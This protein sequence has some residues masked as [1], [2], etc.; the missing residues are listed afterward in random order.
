MCGSNEKVGLGNR[1]KRY[2]RSKLRI[3][4]VSDI[5]KTFPIMHPYLITVMQ[6]PTSRIIL[7]MLFECFVINIYVVHISNPK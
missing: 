4:M 7:L 2:I 3:K 6:N 5:G 1:Q